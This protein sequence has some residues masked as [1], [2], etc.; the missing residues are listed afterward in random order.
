[1]P[2]ISNTDKERKE[3]LEAIG[4]ARFEEL[5]VNI[6]EKLRLTQPL[7][8]DEPLS[9]LE[10]TRRINCI[11][12]KNR[13]SEA[14]NSFMGAGV[15][16]HFIPAA[17]DHIII[18]PE[19]LT[20]Y[21]P[22]QAEVSQGTLQFIYEF[23]TLICEL[24]GMEIANAGMY[25]GASAAAEAL[26]MASRHTRKEKVILAGTLH[27]RFYDV[28]RSYTEDVGLELVIAPVK[29]GATDLDELAKL[30]DK[31]T[32]GVLVQTPNYY[33]CLEDMQKIDELVHAQKKA[34]LIAAVDPISL[35]VLN[36]PA[37][38]HAD[39]VVGEGQALGNKM[40]Y[41]GPLFGFFASSFSLQRS[42]PGRIVGGTLDLDGK[43][44]YALTLQTREQ[45]IR[46]AKATSNICSNQ[47]LACLAATVY[48][49]LMGR[50]GL[51]E[52]AEQS[53]IKAH[54]LAEKI[55]KLNGFEI[56]FDQPFFKEFTVKTPIPAKE[57]IDKLVE[58]DILAGV[59]LAET[60]MKNGLLIAVTEKKTKAQ[61]DELV[62]A[63]EEVNN[64]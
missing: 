17:V 30:I 45:H 62:K 37:E 50:K 41:G 40:N 56:A 52:I 63:L 54:Y 55:G 61:M 34:L 22:Y 21:T 11:A 24:T 51:R 32:A 5:L 10:V 59:N 9:E 64:G 39:I 60:G 14:M 29:K 28:I 3:M 49:C 27:P 57:L 19:F 42:M 47:S 7:K 31:D 4:V 26:L 36:S 33:G 16:D 44:G 53:T 13:H 18:R 58:K 1:M 43:R 15:Y 6:P 35:N 8:L 20:A 23:Q 2:F 46:R 12:A 25:D 38:Y 48:M